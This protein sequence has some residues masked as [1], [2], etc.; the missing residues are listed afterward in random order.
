M[1]C[2]GISQPFQC[3]FANAVRKALQMEA[4]HSRS[5][6][7]AGLVAR[8]GL[9]LLCLDGMTHDCRNDLLCSLLGSCLQ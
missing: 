1:P 4:E 5:M 7:L 3:T 2:M 6:R 9:E 8:Q